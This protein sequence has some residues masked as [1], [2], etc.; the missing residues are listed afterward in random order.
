[1]VATL[2]DQHH[3]YV[4]PDGRMNIAGVSAANVGYV[5]DALA[6]VMRTA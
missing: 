5:A 1:M 2:R 6:A 4:A 3:V